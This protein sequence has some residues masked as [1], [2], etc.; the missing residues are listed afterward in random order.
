MRTVTACCLLMGILT[1]CQNTNRYSV[2]G[3]EIVEYEGNWDV[4]SNCCHAAMSLLADDLKKENQLD[5][6]PPL[7]I[8]GRSWSEED[9]VIAHRST[10]SCSVNSQG[11]RIEISQIGN[12]P[13][14]VMVESPLDDPRLINYL[15]KLFSNFEVEP[16]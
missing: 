10:L 14:M 12:R 4:L 7:N 8:A 2:Y 1:G 15:M 3:T 9:R 13:A 16:V 5:S 6:S 11:Y